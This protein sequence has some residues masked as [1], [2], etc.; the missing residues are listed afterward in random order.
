M[1]ASLAFRADSVQTQKVPMKRVSF[2][3]HIDHGVLSIDP[4]DFELPLGKLA[5][6][7]HL[8]TRSHPAHA[9]IDMRLSDLHLDQFKGKD[10]SEAPLGGIM[11]SRARLEGRGNSAHAIAADSSGTI[12][13]VVP[14][15]I[16]RTIAEL[17]GINVLTGLGLRSGQERTN[18]PDSLRCGRVSD[19]GRGRPRRALGHRYAASDQRGRPH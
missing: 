15:E 5:G 6:Q 19:R 1:D 16:R 9:A 18:S 8:D 2:Q 7:V 11:L 12:T 3:L 14:Q 17:T 13:A 4:V 10:A